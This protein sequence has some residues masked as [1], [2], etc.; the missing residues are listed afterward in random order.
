MLSSLLRRIYSTRRP[1]TQTTRQCLVQLLRV[2]GCACRCRPVSCCCAV[3]RHAQT[4]PIKQREA[5]SYVGAAEEAMVGAYDFK[6][7]AEY[8]SLPQLLVSARAAI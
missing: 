2:R 4:V 1:S 8:A 3:H 5:L 7:P 6:V